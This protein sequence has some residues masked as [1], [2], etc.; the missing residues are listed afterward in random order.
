[1]LKG[2]L[3]EK[4]SNLKEEKN[5]V[6]LAHNYQSKEIQL[7]ADYLGGSLSLARRS[8]E[9]DAD[10]IVFAGVDF[11]AEMT[12]ILNPKKK[13]VMTDSDAT[14]PL[15]EHLP[16]EKVREAKENHPTAATVLYVNTFSDAKAEA[17]V[18]CTSSNASEIVSKV[19]EEKVL[20]GPDRNLSSLVQRETDKDVIP[21][22]EDGYCYVHKMIFPEEIQRLKER[23]GYTEVIVHPECDPEIQEV[24]DYVCSTGDMIPKV[25]E[26]S[27]DRFVVGTETG[28][29]ERLRRD[30]PD[31]EFVP[32]LRAAVCE[33]MKKHSLEKV[34]NSL[35]EEQY[36]VE[37]P[38]DV[39]VEAKRAIERMLEMS[40]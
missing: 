6:L 9:L 2:D 10:L 38:E 14:C 26:S 11:M 28:M 34:V 40:E 8:K 31:K 36:V 1:M 4:I 16:V 15:A 18:I 29:V 23:Q 17:D 5:A 25:R 3:V 32:A 27:A 21:I 35:E 7:A 39:A 37:V 12:S 22:P 20:F 13:V 33:D 30:F 24:A 19:G